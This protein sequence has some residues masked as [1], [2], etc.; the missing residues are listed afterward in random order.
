V[1]VLGTV[2]VLDPGDA[3][4]GL[5]ALTAK[6]EQYRSSPPPGPVLALEPV[7][8]LFWRAAERG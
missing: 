1:Q 4:A 7:R 8:C 6:Y 3:D 2:R 5:R